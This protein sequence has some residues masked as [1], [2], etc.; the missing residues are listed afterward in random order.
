M[1]S[2]T[3]Q[4]NALYAAADLLAAHPGLPKPYVTCGAYSDGRPYI[5][6]QWFLT[7]DHDDLTE[8]KAAAARIVR[9]IGG[10]WEKKES[11][12]QFNFLRDHGPL[13]LRVQVSR[14]AVCERVVTG[15]TTVKRVV[16][17]QEAVDAHTVTETVED[18]E[19]V[20]G[21]LL[22]D[23]AMPDRVPA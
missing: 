6:V 18:V 19:W 14:P 1:T 21:S 3:T 17:A 23:D 5:D 13:S 9:A 16:P 11:G 7:I 22:A 10:H 8:Q 15:T 2:S 20:C 4:P 12:E